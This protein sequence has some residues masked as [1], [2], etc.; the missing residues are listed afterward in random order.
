M[1]GAWLIA[2]PVPAVWQELVAAFVRP[3]LLPFT[4]TALAEAQRSGDDAEYFARARQLLDLLPTWTD[5][6][7][8]F[9]Y[10][11]A[12]DADPGTDATGD[13][14]WQRLQTALA[15]L[16]SARP[17]AGR[18]EI[19]LL[20][21]MAFLPEVAAQQQPLLAGRLRAG[22]GA[23]ALADHYLAEAERLGAS[24]E[25]RELRTFLAPKL[26]AGLLA[27]GERSQARSVLE[28]A[29]LRSA[30][31]RDRELATE[32]ARRL[33]EVRR[34]L[35]GDTAVDLAAVHDDPRFAPLW[36]HLR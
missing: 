13:A 9:A 8:V 6:H 30:E 16:E 4:W 17:Q 27:A 2:P 25:V 11:L 26:V 20:Q 19:E 36:P 5:G 18:R 1:A 10:R 3:A 14:A 29:I 24:P 34:W 33:D 35:A 22:G 31:V 32:W 12:L 28:T 21:T 15:W 7:A 23:A